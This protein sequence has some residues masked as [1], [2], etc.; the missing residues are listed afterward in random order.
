MYLF[1]IRKALQ[2]DC[3]VAYEWGLLTNALDIR[4]PFIGSKGYCHA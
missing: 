2:I 1:V 4:T 3:Y